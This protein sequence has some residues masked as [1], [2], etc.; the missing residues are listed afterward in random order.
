M[1]SVLTKLLSFPHDM[2]LLQD[3][4]LQLILSTRTF[5]ILSKGAYQDRFQ[6]AFFVLNK[7]I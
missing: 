1:L 2:I 3:L 6:S 4:I 7:L 5:Q